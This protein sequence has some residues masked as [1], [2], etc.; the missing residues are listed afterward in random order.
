MTAVLSERGSFK[1][2]L[3]SNEYS[4]V[5]EKIQ[6]TRKPASLRCNYWNP[7]TNTLA[8]NIDPGDV[9]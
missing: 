1:R 9:P 2:H 8:N 7:E 5:V 3:S 6:N 4:T